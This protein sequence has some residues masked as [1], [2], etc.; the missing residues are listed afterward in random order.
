MTPNKSY[1]QFTTAWESGV[2]LV[3]FAVVFFARLRGYSFV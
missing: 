1:C 2:S 3:S